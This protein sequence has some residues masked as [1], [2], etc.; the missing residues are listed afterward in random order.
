MIFGLATNWTN[1]SAWVCHC[2]TQCHNSQGDQSA[3]NLK[4]FKHDFHPLAL[5]PLE[6]RR[7]YEGGAKALTA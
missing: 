7:A 5:V 2:D 4:I 3:N 1:A 6:L